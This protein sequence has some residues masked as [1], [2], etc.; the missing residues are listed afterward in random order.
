MLDAAAG[1]ARAAARPGRR[2]RRR[3]TS[4]ARGWPSSSSAATRRLSVP[5]G[6]AGVEPPRR[7]RLRARPELPRA[8]AELRRAADRPQRRVRR[9]RRAAHLGGSA[10]GPAAA[11]GSP[12]RWPRRRSA[13]AR[14]SSATRCGCRTACAGRPRWGSPCSWPG[15]PAC[16]TP[17]GSRSGTLSVLRSNA[18]STGQSVVRGLLGT[19]AGFVLGARARLARRHQPRAAVGPA[20]ARGPAR[21]ARAG[22]DR[23]RHRARRRSRSSC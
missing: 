10:A 23:L 4:C 15:W 9:G 1:P 12:A 6:A 20:P 5:A 16:R 11:P 21:R 2:C 3:W 8:G 18:L 19:A 14:T 13:R 22:G 17:S 7:A